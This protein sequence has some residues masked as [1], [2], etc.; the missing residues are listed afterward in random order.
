MHYVWYGCGASRLLPR[1]SFRY[2]PSKHPGQGEFGARLLI[3]H[4]SMACCFERAQYLGY[5]GGASDRSNDSRRG[6]LVQQLIRRSLQSEP[7]AC[8]CQPADDGSVQEWQP[9]T[10]STALSRSATATMIRRAIWQSAEGIHDWT[11]LAA[12]QSARRLRAETIAF[13]DR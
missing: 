2:C 6:S 13:W 7:S 8:Q 1:G 12:R 10:G 3:L 9:A 11:W 4:W 5:A